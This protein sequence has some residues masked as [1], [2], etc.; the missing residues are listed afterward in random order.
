MVRDEE[1][2]TTSPDVPCVSPASIA[3]VTLLFPPDLDPP[4]PAGALGCGLTVARPSTTLHPGDP[5][6]DFT[7]PDSTGHPERLADLLRVA[8]VLLFFF[9]GTWCPN[10]RKQWAELRPAMAKLLMSGVQCRGILA[11]AR[12]SVAAY[13]ESPGFPF[14]MLID[15]TRAVIKAYGVWHLLGLDAFNIARPSTFLIDEAGQVRWI[16]V[17]S[18]QMDRP[19]IET[20]LGA[21][22]EH[23]S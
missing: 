12:P 8:P 11:Q 9:R 16:F 14:P 6:P 18:H 2:E 23:R 3:P 7:L 1:S 20:L 4:A 10:C 15:E 19:S 5:A 13:A 17:S 22:R 21:I